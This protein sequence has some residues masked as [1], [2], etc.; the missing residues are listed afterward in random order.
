ML[1]CIA[2]VADDDNAE[3]IP[4]VLKRLSRVI[5][6]LYAR[7]SQKPGG[8]INRNIV[9]YKIPVQCKFRMYTVIPYPG[10]YACNEC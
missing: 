9:S 7:T 3:L 10:K 1:N 2:V 5:S 8:G 6:N 4:S